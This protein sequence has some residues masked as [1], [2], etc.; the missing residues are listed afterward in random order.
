MPKEDPNGEAKRVHL[1]QIKRFYCEEERK[2]DTERRLEQGAR[3]E[4]D[5]PE[6]IQQEVR[7]GKKQKKV[8]PEISERQEEVINRREGRYY[9]RTLRRDKQGRTRA[10]DKS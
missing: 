3:E 9:L 4:R 1:D 8:I 7:P 6:V 5:I 10:V 2:A